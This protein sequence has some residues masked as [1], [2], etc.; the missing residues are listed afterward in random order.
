[1][2]DAETSNNNEKKIVMVN[3][4][5][6]LIINYRKARCHQQ[7]TYNNATYVIVVTKEANLPNNKM[8]QAKGIRSKSVVK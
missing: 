7:T 6:A 2:G 8:N 3:R 4:E 5:K 1:M